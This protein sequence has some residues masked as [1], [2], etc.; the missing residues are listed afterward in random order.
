MRFLPSVQ[1][2]AP[3]VRGELQ[4]PCAANNLGSTG[5]SDARGE[6]LM[7]GRPVSS[8][9]K[10]SFYSLHTAYCSMLMYSFTRARERATACCSILTLCYVQ[11]DASKIFFLT[12]T[13]G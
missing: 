11:N 12:L 10:C 7:A 6:V 13:T 9:S 2:T 5:I 1:N 8:D 3:L 4:G